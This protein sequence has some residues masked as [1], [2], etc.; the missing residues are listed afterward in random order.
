MKV[1]RSL[2]FFLTLATDKISPP[3]STTELPS[4]RSI[5]N[6]LYDPSQI[7][8]N[9]Q[10]ADKMWNEHAGLPTVAFKYTNMFTFPLASSHDE[11]FAWNTFRKDAFLPILKVLVFFHFT[12]QKFELVKALLIAAVMLHSVT[13]FCKKVCASCD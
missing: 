3:R 6:Q 11:I 13:D 4:I 8:C 7:W 10:A 9:R 12:Y 2:D 1:C 5:Q